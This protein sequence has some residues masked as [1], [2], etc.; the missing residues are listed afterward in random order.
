MPLETG[1][2][3][4]ELDDN[5]P[6][7]A[8]NVSLGDDHIRLLKRCVQGSFPAF[9]GNTGTPKSVTKTEDEINDTAEKSVAETI[10]GAWSFSVSIDF[11]G[12]ITALD[13]D[14]IAA[15]DLLDKSA[16]ET[17]SGAYTFAAAPKLVNGIALLGRNAANDADHTLLQLDA[18]DIV[19]VGNF[20]LDAVF[21]FQDTASFQDNIGFTARAVTRA[22]GGWLVADTQG[23]LKKAGFRNGDVIT[24][25]ADHT[26][27]QDNEG[28]YLRMNGANNAISFPGLEAGTE[29]IISTAIVSGTTLEGI[30]TTLEWLDGSG[31]IQTGNRNMA[32]GS[33]VGYKY[34]GITQ[35][36]I[37]GNGLT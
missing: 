37:F 8:D 22:A 12:G 9:V 24:I 10:G 17:I 7:G 18:G 23:V 29:G 11:A 14:G 26:I 35:I 28:Q 5:N 30:G 21:Q 19:R 13:Y 4:P 1:N 20:P 33:I 25:T 2:F 27:T 31:T 15:A 6:L 32:G 34:R 36:L 16:A 3:I